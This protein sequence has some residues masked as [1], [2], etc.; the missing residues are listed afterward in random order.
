MARPEPVRHFFHNRPNAH[1][2]FRFTLAASMARFSAFR[3]LAVSP[4]TQ[5]LAS[6]GWPLARAA[7]L[8]ADGS[9]I[10]NA[11][12]SIYSANGGYEYLA[13]E[14]YD[15]GYEQGVPPFSLS[16]IF[17]RH[18]LIIINDNIKI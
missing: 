6:L 14:I 8:R 1:P 4:I 18:I 17:K 9:R 3:R 16:M 10:S 12:T 15:Y 5:L 13:T 7:K 2:C 11:A